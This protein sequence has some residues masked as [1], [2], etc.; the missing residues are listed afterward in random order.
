LFLEEDCLIYTTELDV[1]NSA[2]F[3]V[4]A[5][6][7]KLNATY[8]NLKLFVD[9][10][11]DCP[12]RLVICDTQW[13]SAGLSIEQLEVFLQSAIDAK[14]EILELLSN[15]QFLDTVADYEENVPSSEFLH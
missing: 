5:E 10:A 6:L 4:S 8:A 12:P 9:V 3:A 14:L 11:D 15:C 2:L 1:R 13:M 7:H